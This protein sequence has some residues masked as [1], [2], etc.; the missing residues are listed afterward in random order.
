MAVLV[1]VLVAVVL[2]RVEYPDWPRERPVAV[3]VLA[4]VLLLLQAV[5]VAA[6]TEAEG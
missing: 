2:D 4:L 1:V 5:A 3:V 6:A